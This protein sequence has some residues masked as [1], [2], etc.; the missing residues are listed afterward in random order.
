MWSDPAALTP[1]L[2][3]CIAIL[4]GVVLLLRSQLSR[5]AAPNA[6]SAADRLISGLEIH[7]TTCLSSHR[8]ART[9]QTAW[10]QHR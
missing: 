2:V 7:G 8:S 5:S 1:P 9:G 6:M 4:I 10:P 3:M